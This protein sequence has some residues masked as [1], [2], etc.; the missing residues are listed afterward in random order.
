MSNNNETS[1]YNKFC[2]CGCFNSF[3]NQEISFIKEYKHWFLVLNWQQNF[4]GRTLL[5]LKAHKT[6]EDRI[7]KW[8]SCFIK[9]YALL[10]L[11]IIGY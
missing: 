11:I 1:L 3:D 9:K 6:V 2:P 5:I 8:I 4:L 10:H 7:S